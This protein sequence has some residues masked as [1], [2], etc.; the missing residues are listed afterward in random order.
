MSTGANDRR[1][2]LFAPELIGM[3]TTT[4]VEHAPSRCMIRTGLL[5]EGFLN[6]LKRAQ[7]RAEGSRSGVG[8]SKHLSIFTDP[9][10]S[11]AGPCGRG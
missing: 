6:T 5:C 7:I 8:P 11:I 4:R 10:H 2:P 1:R 9:P 3:G